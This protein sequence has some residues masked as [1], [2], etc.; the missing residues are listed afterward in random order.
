[1]PHM[2]CLFLNIHQER[3]AVRI[4]DGKEPNHENGLLEHFKVDMWS[5]ELNPVK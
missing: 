5:T 4:L 1:M 2:L 3:V